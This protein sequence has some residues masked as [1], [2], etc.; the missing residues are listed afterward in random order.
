MANAK[1]GREAVRAKVRGKRV[2]VRKALRKKRPSAAA[3]AVKACFGC[4]VG[5]A[6][7]LACGCNLATPASK[8]AGTRACDN[9]TTVNNHFGLVVIPTNGAPP[10]VVGLAGPVIV[11]VS[12]VN[13]TIAQSADTEGGDRTDLAAVPTLSA[14]VTGDKPIEALQKAVM[15]FASPQEAL[16]VAAENLVKKFGLGATTNALKQVSA[17]CT[18]GSCSD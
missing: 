10:V 2:A 14:G 12:D 3:R 7:V 13:G 11:N 16:S 4:V 18:D 17:G 8:S 15:A 5:L 9:V 6:L 1:K